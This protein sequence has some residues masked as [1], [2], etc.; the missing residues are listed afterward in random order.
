MKRSLERMTQDHQGQMAMMG[1][2]QAPS[3]TEVMRQHEAHLTT[4]G[5]RL[6]ALE[7]ELNTS[8]PNSKLVAGHARE[9]LKACAGMSAVN[10]DAMPHPKK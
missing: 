2:R 7:V 9:I 10:G 8:Q 5:K 6:A 3:M 4:L 1:D